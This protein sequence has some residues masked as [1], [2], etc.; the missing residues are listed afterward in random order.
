MQFS[1][2]AEMEWSGA[3]GNGSDFRKSGPFRLAHPQAGV[4]ERNHRNAAALGAEM[5][6]HTGDTP[7]RSAPFGKV[8]LSLFPVFSTCNF[9]IR[10]NP[11]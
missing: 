11:Q 6:A 7:Y 2:Q 8:M 10:T 5:S 9:R 3:T 1:P 4:S